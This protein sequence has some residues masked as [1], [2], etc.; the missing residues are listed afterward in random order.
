MFLPIL[1]LT[2]PLLISTASVPA[3]DPNVDLCKNLKPKNTT[4]YFA[5]GKGPYSMKLTPMPK[6]NVI[7]VHLMASEGNYFEGESIEQVCN[8][9][10]GNGR[11]RIKALIGHRHFLIFWGLEKI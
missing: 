5:R 8:R 4:S 3:A 1:A 9:F 11:G 7:D 6:E 10:H 2:L